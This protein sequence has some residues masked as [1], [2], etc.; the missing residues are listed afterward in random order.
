MNETSLNQIDSIFSSQIERLR[1]KLKL[2]N[3]GMIQFACEKTFL[4]SFDWMKSMQTI[5]VNFFTLFTQ[6]KFSRMTFHSTFAAV[7]ARNCTKKIYSKT[8]RKAFLLAELF[9]H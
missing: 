4:L 8:M 5:R 9:L 2:N 3:F 7:R 6:T 1:R